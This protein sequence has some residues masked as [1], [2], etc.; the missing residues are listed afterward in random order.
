MFKKINSN[1][2]HSNNNEDDDDHDDNNAHRNMIYVQC[3]ICIDIDSWPCATHSKCNSFPL[4]RYP[5]FRILEGFHE[6]STCCA[7]DQT[8]YFGHDWII[9]YKT[10]GIQYTLLPYMCCF[11]KWP[12]S[13]FNHE[14]FSRSLNSKNRVL[15]T[16]TPSAAP[17]Q[18]K[19]NHAQLMLKKME[20]S[21]QCPP[22]FLGFPNTK[23]RNTIR[24]KR[25]KN[26]ESLHTDFHFNLRNV[27]FGA[28]CLTKNVWCI[29]C[30][31]IILCN[32]NVIQ[33]IQAL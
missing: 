12:K 25:S 21:S 7:A 29:N 26:P 18:Q 24:L 13:D 10:K 20:L 6:A 2:K 14:T 11:F 32:K 23:S 8:S 16:K 27:N 22:F 3:I 33:M 5:V 19:N 28:L 4:N 17:N 9:N 30:V 1:D 31:R 15:Q